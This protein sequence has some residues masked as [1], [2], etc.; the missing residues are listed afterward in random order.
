VI[1]R[2]GIL[3]APLL[4]EDVAAPGLFEV[5]I[6]ELLHRYPHEFVH[7]QTALQKLFGRLSHLH[8]DEDIL[9]L[10]GLYLAQQLFFVLG[11]PWGLS[12]QHF[13]EYNTQRPY[14]TL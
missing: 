11:L 9:D 7:L 5:E 6:C 12:R 4:C 10:F 1:V 8:F 13:K 2:P 3:V 14:V